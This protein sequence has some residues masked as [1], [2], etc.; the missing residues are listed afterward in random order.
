MRKHLRLRRPSPAMVVALVALVSA[1]AGPA[2]AE[3]AA[4]LARS[5]VIDGGKIKKRSITGSRLKNDSVTGVQVRESSLRRVA[6]AERADSAGTATTASSAVTAASA[7][8]AANAR[9]ADTVGGLT[10]ADLQEPAAYA[11]VKEAPPSLDP[12]SSKNVLGVSA[13]PLITG[14]YCF[15]LPFTPKSVS[16]TDRFGGQDDMIMS[17]ASGAEPFV[18]EAGAEA[19]VLSFEA[20]LQNYSANGGS[21]FVQFFR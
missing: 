18:C 14:S 2:L 19:S 11:V 21:F 9:N 13:G 5:T 17:A 7:A 8:T 3:Q 1:F 10:P 6:R 20:D 15:D 16:A 12:A 4:N